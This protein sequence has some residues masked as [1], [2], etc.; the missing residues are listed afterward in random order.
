MSNY[1]NTLDQLKRELHELRELRDSQPAE[2]T[3]FDHFQGQAQSKADVLILL[4]TNEDQ[5]ADLDNEVVRCEL[6]SQRAEDDRAQSTATWRRVT[7]G[8]VLSGVAI[9]AA[10]LLLGLSFVPI[11]VG[12]LVLAGAAG[13]GYWWFREEDRTLAAVKRC[14]QQLQQARGEREDFA[15]QVLPGAAA[16]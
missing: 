6:A 5:L 3:G 12:L 9:V 16:R 8:L 1:Q 2:S 14:S 4:E 7:V 11:L 15:Q 13:S 10:S